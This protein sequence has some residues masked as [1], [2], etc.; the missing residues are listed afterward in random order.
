MNQH[1]P[2]TNASAIDGAADDA[3]AYDITGD[4][5]I[6]LRRYTLHPDQREVLI[7]LFERE[8]IE[9]QETL[10]MSVI[11]LF[12]DVDHPDTFTWLR[13]FADMDARRDALEAFYGGPVW[14]R[15]RDAANATMIDSD[16]VL[17]LTS[18]SMPN[19]SA[20]LEPA[21]PVRG[22][23][24]VTF[25]VGGDQRD[26]ELAELA[27]RIGHIEGYRLEMYLRSLHAV[28][29]F[30]ALPVRA[31]A[32]VVVAVLTTTTAYDAAPTPV[33]WEQIGSCLTSLTKTEAIRLEPTAHS[34]LH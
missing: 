11:G 33:A 1:D 21:R 18:V 15:H 26:T 28:D 3:I 4:A 34:Q 32:N 16:D 14:A 8:F 20:A 5:V 25:H 23:E 9:P 7:E 22:F 10:G 30:P 29:T 6:E 17:L 24:I 12:R 27:H 31:D 13:G 19:V 2:T